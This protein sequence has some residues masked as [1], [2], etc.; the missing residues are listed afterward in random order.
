MIEYHAE[1]V[2]KIY[3]TQCLKNQINSM[4]RAI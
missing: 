4:I 1:G 2:D 3:H